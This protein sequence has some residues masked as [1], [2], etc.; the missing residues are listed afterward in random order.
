MGINWKKRSGSA[1]TYR[2]LLQTIA[3]PSFQPTSESFS[4][5]K[6]D[7]EIKCEEWNLEN[8]ISKFSRQAYTGHVTMFAFRKHL[9]SIIDPSTFFS[10]FDTD[11]WRHSK[12]HPVISKTAKTP[13]LKWYVL[14]ERRAVT[15]YRRLYSGR[16]HGLLTQSPLRLEE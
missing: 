14:S 9:L 11:Q 7:F 8:W 16:P 6:I 4:G 2:K 12:E 10:T 15:I 1:D 13:D 3:K 5:K